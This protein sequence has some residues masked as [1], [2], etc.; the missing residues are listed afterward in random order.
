[1]VIMFHITS[2]N[3]IYR[4]ILLVVGDSR[5]FNDAIDEKNDLITITIQWY[6]SHNQY[7]IDRN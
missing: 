6:Y 5:D 4:D 3:D 1:M 2:W 7:F